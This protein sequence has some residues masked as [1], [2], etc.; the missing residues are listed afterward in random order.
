MDN[1][2]YALAELKRK[3]ERPTEVTVTDADIERVFTLCASHKP[4]AGYELIKHLT[5]LIEQLSWLRAHHLGEQGDG[6]TAFLSGM[7]TAY[8]LLRYSAKRGV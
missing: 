4:G 8:E 5:R 2:L 3:L 6:V 7:I 1:W